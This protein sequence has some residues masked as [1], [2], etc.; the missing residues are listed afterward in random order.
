MSTDKGPSASGPIRPRAACR[1]GPAR[2]EATRRAEAGPATAT[3]GR[4][5]S[6]SGSRGG[7][8]GFLVPAAAALLAFLV[9][10]VVVA[11]TG[12]NPLGGLQGD[13]RGDGPQRRVRTCTEEEPPGGVERPPA[14]ADRLHAARPLTR[15]RSPSPSAAG[16]STSAARA[17][18]SSALF[19]ALYVGTQ[20]R[21]ACRR[22]LHILL[23]SVAPIVAGLVW[24]GIAGFLKASVG[25]H[26]VITTIMLNWIA[27]FGGQYLFEL[28]GP[29]QGENPS[30][31][32]LRRGGRVGPAPGVPGRDRPPAAP[33]RRPRS[34]GGR[35]SSTHL[36]LN[37][38]T[39]GYQVRAVGFNPEAARYGGIPV[40]RNY[41]LAL[42]I[43]GAFAGLARRHRHPRLE[44]H[45]GDERHPGRPTSA[46]S[47]SR[48]RCSGATRRSG[49]SSRRC[50]SPRSAP[51]RRRAS[52]TRRPSRP[53]SPGTSRTMIQA[54]IILF[55]G[56]ELLI[57]Y[58]WG[59]RRRFRPRRAA[60]R[61]AGAEAMTTS[62]ATDR[63]PELRRPD[64]RAARD[65]DPRDRRSACSRSGSPCRRGRCGSP[66][67]RSW[68]GCWPPSRGSGRSCATS[69]SSASGRSSPPRSARRRRD[70][71]AGERRL[72]SLEGVVIVGLARGDAPVRDAAR[73]R[74]D[75]RDLLRARRG[76]EH[77][78]RGDDAR[79]RVLRHLGG[80]EGRALDGR[81][82]RRDGGRRL[83]RRDP[84]VLLDPPARRP[85]RRRDGDQLPRARPHRAI[86][87]ATSTRR[88]ERRRTSRGSPTSRI[89]GLARRPVPR[90]R[91]RRAEPDDLADRHP[92]RRRLLRALQDTGRPA[93]PRGRGAPQGG[94]HGRDL[95]LR[96]PLR[97]RSSSRGCSRRSAAPTSRSGSSARSTRT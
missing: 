3:A 53:S 59:A 62:T 18:S 25:A 65:R 51:A 90:G 95:G 38:T 34:R 84:R 40:G 20:L 58:I 92:P 54:L 71:G 6:R 67:S 81:P 4:S 21:R 93:P 86:S 72:D 68:S 57:V 28:G 83:P 79:R 30:V 87:S 77:R 17:S 75:R 96:G 52:S 37:R 22:S 33:H 32:A 74:G 61:P 35:S 82:A 36:I 26:E 24:G 12:H 64:H 48:S 23:A 29:L 89:P 55:V 97:A 56:A 73:L 11:A 88:R 66:A 46:S 39:L 63:S 70:L 5:G 49:S 31:P 47:A 78:P 10:G 9:G 42:A 80:G 44:V 45:D 50:S 60:P 43:S 13:L 15:S 76:R 94:G 19:A 16:C 14:D 41:F 8:G 85:D 27:V 91:V 1:A 7:L 2:I 69:A